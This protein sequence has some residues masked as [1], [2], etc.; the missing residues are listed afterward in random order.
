MHF[1]SVGG[2]R[3]RSD[4]CF[5]IHRLTKNIPP[6][7]FKKELQDVYA[8]EAKYF[9]QE[10]AITLLTRAVSQLLNSGEQDPWRGE[11]RT[12]LLVSVARKW[13]T[14][15]GQKF[16]DDLKRDYDAVLKAGNNRIT[17]V[18]VL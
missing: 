13:W 12:T 18:P 17:V 1:A 7:A 9:N 3:A 5:C 14:E 2:A 6:Q 15:K 16:W 4:L 10:H 8:G 11:D